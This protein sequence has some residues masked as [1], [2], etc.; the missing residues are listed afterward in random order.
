MVKKVNLWRPSS[1]EAFFEGENDSYDGFFYWMNNFKIHFGYDPDNILD[2]DLEHEKI[3]PCVARFRE[4]YPE[5]CRELAL[6]CNNMVLISATLFKQKLY[7]AYLKM[8][9][10]VRESDPYV[11]EENGTINRGYL[12]M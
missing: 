12:I 11:K 10:L 6:H 9:D 8:V 7:E 2:H 3:Y 1:I 5:L 4:K